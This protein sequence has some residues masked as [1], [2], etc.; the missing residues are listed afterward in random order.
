MGHLWDWLQGGAPA[1]RSL[2]ALCYT[3]FRLG[4][5]SFLFNNCPRMSPASGRHGQGAMC[6]GIAR[7]PGPV[8]PMKSMTLALTAEAASRAH[9][10]LLCGRLP[11]GA[12]GGSERHGSLSATASLLS[13]EEQPHS[14]LH[15][16][17]AGQGI[18]ALCF[19]GRKD[20]R[21]L[22]GGETGP[23]CNIKHKGLGGSVSLFLCSDDLKGAYEPCYLRASCHHVD[24]PV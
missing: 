12:E 17:P 19:L 2:A 23:A 10:S 24:K 11:R 4:I 21:T 5:L 7:P 22:Q 13:T 20:E 1:W 9:P 6:C 15:V 16:I 18:K 8:H 14:Q 3:H